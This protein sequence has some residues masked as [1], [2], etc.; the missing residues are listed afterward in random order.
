[1]FILNLFKKKPKVKEPRDVTALK[2]ELLRLK[3]KS[4]V[5]ETDENVKRLA[6]DASK[7]GGKPFVPSDFVWPTFTS[8]ED[9]ETYPLSF[10]C[11]LNLSELSKY[12]EED[13]LPKKG[14]LLFFYECES[15]CCGFDPLDKGATK[16][17]YYEDTT[18]FVSYDVPSDLYEDYIIPELAIH[19]KV[20]D[21][22]PS[23]DEL[24]F[25]SSVE[26]DYDDWEA[27][28]DAFG[29]NVIDD[30]ER[31]K[32][33]GYADVI[34]S[35]MLTDCERTS[36]GLYCGDPESFASTSEDEANDIQKHA[37]DWML[38]LQLDTITKGDFEF[39]FGDCGRLFFYI[40]KEDLVNQQFDNVWFAVQF[41]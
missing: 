35:E 28:M 37:T 19:C 22:Y 38:L 21:S 20:M 40:R 4:I 41:C 36:R 1:M 39:M 29:I 32:V 34:Q 3:K 6:L 18:N 8:M 5:L 25:Y 23:E 9:D 14:L 15:F 33:L 10:F 17:F 31:H 27:V 2:E 30:L 26:C 7:I 12:D 11:Q 16:V 24:A 13:L